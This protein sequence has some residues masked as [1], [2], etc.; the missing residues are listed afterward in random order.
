M[1]KKKSFNQ[2]L[3]FLAIKKLHDQSPSDV[4]AKEKQ[5]ER[6]CKEVEIMKKLNHGNIVSVL[7]VPR[8]FRSLT[9][10][11]LLAME[12]CSQGDLRGVSLNNKTLCSTNR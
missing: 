3:T 6:W 9:K 2:H 7:E 10:L 5:T 4:S 1:E 11:P 8:E 12:Y